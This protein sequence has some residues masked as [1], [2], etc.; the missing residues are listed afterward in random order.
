MSMPDT[1]RNIDAHRHGPHQICMMC[2]MPRLTSVIPAQQAAPM[3][4]GFPPV[5]I[6]FTTSLF[7]PIAAIAM[8][9]KNFDRFL[10]GTNTSV[11]TPART[12]TVVI[13]EA[14]TKYRMNMGNALR[15]LKAS[16]FDPELF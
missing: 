6:S 5:R 4:T 1:G 7:R 13:T 12:Q 9:M 16:P 11:L 10:S 3:T 15:R 2:C 14:R 8:T